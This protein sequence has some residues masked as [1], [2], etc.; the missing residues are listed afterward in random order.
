MKTHIRSIPRFISHPQPTNIPIL[1]PEKLNFWIIFTDTS[2]IC[3][4]LFLGEKRKMN[5]KAEF[6][7]IDMKAIDEEFVVLME[8]FK[9]SFFSTFGKA[10]RTKKIQ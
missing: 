5:D 8:R 10:S 9:T 4:W 7:L 1:M 3:R 6:L 2:H